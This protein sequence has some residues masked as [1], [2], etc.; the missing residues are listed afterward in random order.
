MKRAFI[1]S[2]IMVLGTGLFAQTSVENILAEVEKNNTTL[3]SIRK[4]IDA[5]K[6]GNKTGILPGNPEAE[7][8]FLRGN[9]SVIG[10]RNDFIIKQSID[11][12]TAYSYKNQISDLKNDQA[13]LVYKKHRNEI[14]LQTRLVCIELTYQNALKAELDVRLN[15]ARQIANSYKSK[16]NIGEVGILE[17]NKAQVNLLII[18]KEAEIN[19]IERNAL[20]SELAGL[21]GGAEISFNDS[22]F[23]QKNVPPDFESWYAQVESGNPVLQWLNQE[24]SVSQKQ[25]QLSTALSLPKLNAGYMSEKVVGQHYQGI[26]V[27]VS[28]PLWENKNT[29]RYAKAKTIAVQG[30]EVD[31]KLKFYIEM[32]RLHNKVISLQNSVNDYRQSLKSYS[33]ERLLQKALDNGEISLADYFFE[34]TMYYESINQLL[35]MEKKL[36]IA[37]AELNRY[38]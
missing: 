6:L 13:D 33:N 20:F 19:E 31:A 12:P 34:L 25:K 29:V 2:A 5:E 18:A 4:N 11:F 37:S 35:E 15:N 38:L 8:N 22:S 16:F 30:L 36:N 10:S 21:N 1:I 32:K 28:V 17:Y 3:S 23:V 7:F 27:G 26:T 24:I 14:L 9:P